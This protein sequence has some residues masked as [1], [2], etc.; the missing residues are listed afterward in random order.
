[1]SA[2]EQSDCNIY[3]ELHIHVLMRDLASSHFHMSTM[4]AGCKDLAW[5]WF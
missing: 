2:A 1:M 5:V 4:I 3:L